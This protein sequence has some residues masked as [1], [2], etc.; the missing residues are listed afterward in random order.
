MD[1]ANTVPK[2]YQYELP[3]TAS[4]EEKQ[5]CVILQHAILYMLYHT[6]VI[7]LHRSRMLLCMQR[8]NHWGFISHEKARKAAGEISRIGHDLLKLK[9]ERYLPPSSVTSLLYAINIHIVHVS[10]PCK[11]TSKQATLGLNRCMNV[12]ERLRETYTSAEYAYQF[13][14]LARKGLSTTNHFE[15]TK[16]HG[17]SALHYQHSREFPSQSPSD[18]E[19]AGTFLAFTVADKTDA[20]WAHVP[21]QPANNTSM[22]NHDWDNS[23][24]TSESASGGSVGHAD[25]TWAASVGFIHQKDNSY[26]I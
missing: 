14:K 22:N 5:P 16:Q 15:E 10:S 12:L 26:K 1:W 7:C 8:Y 2:R 24:F 9:L 21:Q 11:D 18:E 20:N 17:S 25:S 3:I 6:A 23:I 13:L 4:K 19:D